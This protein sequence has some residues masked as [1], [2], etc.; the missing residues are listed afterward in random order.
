M[1]EFKNL[2]E[3]EEFMDLRFP[4]L[5]P[6]DKIYVMKKGASYIVTAD[7]RGARMLGYNPLIVKIG[8]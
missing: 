5:E 7:Y 3:A 1:T 4:E 8:I 2:Q 6:G